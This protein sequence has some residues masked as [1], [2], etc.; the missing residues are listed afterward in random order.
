MRLFDFQG[1]TT[2]ESIEKH[3]LQ[4]MQTDYNLLQSQNMVQHYEL[5]IVT[6]MIL[7]FCIA[8]NT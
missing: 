2:V 8:I 5:T 3:S 1:I 7:M 6:I 4:N